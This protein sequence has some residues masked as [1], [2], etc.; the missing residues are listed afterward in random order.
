MVA[1]YR[2]RRFV[3]EGV[4]YEDCGDDECDLFSCEEY[5]SVDIDILHPWTLM[6]TTGNDRNGAFL[7]QYILSPLQD[8]DRDNPFSQ[9]FP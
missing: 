7:I 9:S 3:F 8:V 1:L 2:G 4:D 6:P 5:Y